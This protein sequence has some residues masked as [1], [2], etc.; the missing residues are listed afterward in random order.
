[1][2]WAPRDA[3]RRSICHGN[4]DGPRSPRTALIRAKCLR[5]RLV[6]GVF[7]ATQGPRLHGTAPGGTASIASMIRFRGRAAGTASLASGL[8]FM[9]AQR[10]TLELRKISAGGAGH[11]DAAPQS[12]RE[13]YRTGPAPRRAWRDFVSSM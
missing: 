3:V 6:N 7:S 4:H 12:A 9:S 5:A 11:P 8:E 1:M 10:M 13:R 2:F